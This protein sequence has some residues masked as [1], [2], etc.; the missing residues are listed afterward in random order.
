MTTAHSPSDQTQEGWG[1]YLDPGERLLWEG[2]PASKVSFEA[3]DP[4]QTVFGL[5]FAG[6]AIFWMLMAWGISGGFSASGPGSVVTMIFPLFGLP[7]L[8]VGLYLAFGKLFWSA[9]T[10]GKTRY[11]LTDRRAFIATSARGRQ[12]KSYPIDADTQLDYRPGAKASIYFATEERK[13]AK[14]T[15]YT[16]LVGFQFIPNGDEVYRLIRQIQEGEGR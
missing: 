3:I 2:A 9:F 16:T 12:L 8:A 6:F 15:T 7:F 5:V 10:R 14:G 13:A 1:P 4:K 11:A